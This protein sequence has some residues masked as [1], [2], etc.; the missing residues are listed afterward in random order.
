MMTYNS[1]ASFAVI[2][3][4]GQARIA[5]A[6]DKFDEKGNLIE[7]NKRGNYVAMTEEEKTAINTLEELVTKRMN[8]DNAE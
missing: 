3:D 7:S 6:F 1:L 4:R 2:K 5:Y 8:E